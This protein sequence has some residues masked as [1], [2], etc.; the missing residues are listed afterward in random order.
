M[1]GLYGMAAGRRREEVIE[2]TMTRKQ[3]KA[4]RRDKANR[5]R[6]NIRSNNMSVNPMR[7]WANPFQ[8]QNHTYRLYQI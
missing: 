3:L 6:R 5:K 1:L 2:M 4:L 8:H 7:E